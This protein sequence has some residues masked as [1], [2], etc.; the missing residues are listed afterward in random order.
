MKFLENLLTNWE[1]FLQSLLERYI[2]PLIEVIKRVE[3]LGHEE[4]KQ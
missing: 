3:Y 4:M 2:E 1:V